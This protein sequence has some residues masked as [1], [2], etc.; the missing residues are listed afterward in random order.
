MLIH[1]FLLKNYI[2]VSCYLLK[3]FCIS[4][5]I[6]QPVQ[7]VEIHIPSGWDFLHLCIWNVDIWLRLDNPKLSLDF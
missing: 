4:S 6:S 5:K 7:T 3:L 1:K 2:F